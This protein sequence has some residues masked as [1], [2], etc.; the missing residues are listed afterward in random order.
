MNKVIVVGGG[1]IG[2]LSAYE[3]H[4]N[5]FQVTVIDRQQFG[6]ESTW[7]GG[8]IVS[9]LYPWRYD[10][11]ITELCRISQQIYPE[12]I[13]EMQQATGLD[14]E[15]LPSGMLIVGDYSNE[16][17]QDWAQR[18]NV[19][20]QTI[21][22]AELK[23]LEPGLSEKYHNGYW[24]PQVY[25]LR[26]PRMAALAVAYLRQNNIRLIENQPVNE[27]LV[28]S[29]RA[30]GVKTSSSTYHA[31]A[32]VIAGGAWTSQI[33]SQQ[34]IENPIKPI[35]G[36]MLLLKGKPDV[37]QRIT[38]SQ[39]RY[40]IP[41]KDGRILVGSTTE[42][43]GFDKSTTASIKQELHDYAVSTIPLLERYE[44][45]HHWSGLRPASDN[46]IP[47]I[48]EHPHLKQ[49][50]INS[51]H[52]RNGVVMAPASARLLV[53]IMTQQNTSLAQHLYASGDVDH[54]HNQAND[55]SSVQT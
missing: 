16:R 7:A 20:M 47:V 50:Y 28:E 19:H 25:Q 49:L 32:I 3:L 24:F 44:I 41:R 54:I 35:R 30:S 31:D 43:V 26:N 34:P 37:V 14:A 10:D 46:G 48:A 51:G 15:F 22:Q 40:I 29:N 1:I 11:R 6:Q 42:D 21:P 9:P 17:A 13:D 55:R 5:G 23:Q 27:I 18:V 36:Q 52:Y 2:L 33:L 8:G 39:D 4:R 45:E 53:E 38:L 12:L